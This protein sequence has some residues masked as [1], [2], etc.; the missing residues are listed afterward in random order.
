[1]G[2][3]GQYMKNIKYDKILLKYRLNKCWDKKTKIEVNIIMK[4]LIEDT[5]QITSLAIEYR[6]K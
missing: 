4:Y 5:R 6:T 2:R 3:F 1:M